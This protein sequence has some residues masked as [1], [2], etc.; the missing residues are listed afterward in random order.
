MKNLFFATLAALSLTACSVNEEPDETAKSVT[1]QVNAGF[2]Y[3]VAARAVSGGKAEDWTSGAQITV[4]AV[5]GTDNSKTTSNYATYTLSSGSSDA[6]TSE[7]PY[8]FTTNET[9][10][11]FNAFTYNTTTAPAI[12][13]GKISLSATNGSLADLYAA[14]NN[15]VSYSSPS[16]NF[17]FYHLFS[18]LTINV[19]SGDGGTVSS[20]KVSGYASS[21]TVDVSSLSITKG[22][23]STTDVDFGSPS[24]NTCSITLILVPGEPNLTVSIENTAGRKYSVNVNPTLSA[25]TSYTYNITLS[26]IGLTSV[27]S[28]LYEW[29][30]QSATNVGV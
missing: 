9:S 6:F 28:T 13:D 19:K 20:A 17:S 8:A 4:A 26:S 23:V 12:S 2:E 10:V 27:S 30:T 16:A 25:K 29:Y 18:K 11:N 3:N 5:S 24:N 15:S 7:S 14:S 21:A 1:L 22:D